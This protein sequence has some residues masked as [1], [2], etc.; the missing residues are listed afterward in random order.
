EANPGCKM[1]A[2]HVR[3]DGG[4]DV[5]AR[6]GA[7][8]RKGSLRTGE[9]PLTSRMLRL[10]RMAEV[11][12]LRR[13]RQLDT[14]REVAEAITCARR[15]ERQSDNGGRVVRSFRLAANDAFG[16]ERQDP[17]QDFRMGWAFGA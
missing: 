15:E 16:P 3:V 7:L 11:E 8:F 4:L 13:H 1:S 2:R 9:E 10:A 17:A 14:T 12:F 6:L 5:L